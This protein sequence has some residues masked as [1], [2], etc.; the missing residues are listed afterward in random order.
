MKRGV[1]HIVKPILEHVAREVGVTPAQARAVIDGV[2]RL[3]AEALK[4]DGRLGWPRVGVWT[5]TK[6]KARR[7]R[8]P[9]T[10]EAIGLP[11]TRS[12]RFRPAKRGVFARSE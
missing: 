6:R 5:A 8:N 11:V 12:V 4:Y 9:V 3:G 2:F 7:G 10:G 1:R